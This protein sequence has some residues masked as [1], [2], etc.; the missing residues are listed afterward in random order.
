MDARPLSKRE[1]TQTQ[2]TNETKKNWNTH[3]HFRVYTIQQIPLG[4]IENLIFSSF[5]SFSSLPGHLSP[6]H[7]NK[8]ELKEKRFSEI[9]LPATGRFTLKKKK[10]R[11]NESFEK[12]RAPVTEDFLPGAQG[13]ALSK[14]LF[15]SLFSPSSFLFRQHSWNGGSLFYFSSLFL[16]W[17]VVVVV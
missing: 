15:V 3:P 1:H 16:G 13:E 11:L 7:T 17:P 10:K 9:I 4:V 12:S 5:P 2:Q 14:T 8:S 6:G